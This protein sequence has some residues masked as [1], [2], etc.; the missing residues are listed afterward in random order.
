MKQLIMAKFNTEIAY[1]YI[2]KQFPSIILRLDSFDSKCQ[3]AFSVIFALCDLAIITIDMPE[4]AIW[5]GV[6]IDP[7]STSLSSVT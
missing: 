6:E 7:N 3:R 4:T 5:F 2:S 1:F